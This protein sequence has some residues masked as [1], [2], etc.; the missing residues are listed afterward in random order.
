MW[1]PG[2][3]SPCP[4]T[5]FVS[6]SSA[7]MAAYGAAVPMATMEPAGPS[8]R[9][10]YAKC[11]LMATIATAVVVGSVLVMADKHEEAP[12]GS[13][14]GGA[15]YAVTKPP[16]FNFNSECPCFPSSSAH[17][18]RSTAAAGALAAVQH[19]LPPRET[20]GAQRSVP[21]PAS[22]AAAARRARGEGGRAVVREGS[23]LGV[24]GAA[25]GCAALLRAAGPPCRTAAQE[26]CVLCSWG[27][28]QRPALCAPRWG[29]CSETGG[30]VSRR[31][32]PG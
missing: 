15:Y 21:F 11:A 1:P 2:L 3:G 9:A 20:G 22:G 18:S 14:L 27:A 23:A 30:D 31:V 29:S 12:V 4:G 5:I 10:F 24:V 8:R 28:A 6:S 32:V 19:L 25:H 17:L 16:A 13:E 26:H 7:G